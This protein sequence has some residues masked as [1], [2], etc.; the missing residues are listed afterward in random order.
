MGLSLNEIELTGRKAVRGAGLPWGLAEDAG[1]AVRWLEMVGLPGMAW[2]AGLLV[3]TDYKCLDDWRVRVLPTGWGNVSGLLSPLVVGPSLSD[4]VP[5]CRQQNQ[6]TI[7]LQ[8]VTCPQL[9]AGYLGITSLQTGI[10]VTLLWSHG[11]VH[12]EGDRVWYD[13]MQ[14]PDLDE[15]SYDLTV[16]LRPPDRLAHSTLGIARLGSRAVNDQVLGVLEALAR[17][18]YV[19]NTDMSRLSGAGA[20]LHDSD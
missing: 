3:R 16:D 13:G 18:T 2:L 12:V 4:S 15:H 5:L 7:T 8:A 9:C 20:G 1:R 14:G 17:R 10:P 6:S 19:K 11:S